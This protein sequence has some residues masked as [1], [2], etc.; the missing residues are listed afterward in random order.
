L[1]RSTDLKQQQVVPVN[2]KIILRP[3]LAGILTLKTVLRSEPEHTIFIQ[4]VGKIFF[5]T[6]WMKLACSGAILRILSVY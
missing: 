5:S 2:A 6:V 1:P 3:L 4:N